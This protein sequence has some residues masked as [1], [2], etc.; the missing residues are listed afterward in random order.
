MKQLSSPGK[1][2]NELKGFYVE[3]LALHRALG[4]RPAFLGVKIL[5]EKEGE[6]NVYPGSRIYS[7]LLSNFGLVEKEIFLNFTS[8]PGLLLNAFEGS[9]VKIHWEEYPPRIEGAYMIVRAVVESAAMGD[10]AKI[11]LSLEEEW[12]DENSVFPLTR[13]TGLMIEALIEASRFDIGRREERIRNFLLFIDRLKRVAEDETLLSALE[14]IEGRA[15]KNEEHR[16][17]D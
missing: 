13:A 1:W 14:K 17:K 6:A 5:S 15:R 7:L 8:S 2:R 3:S 10:P 4:N 16:E 12:I 9:R 11:I